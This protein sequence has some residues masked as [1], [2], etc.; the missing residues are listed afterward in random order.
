MLEHIHPDYPGIWLPTDE[1][2]H[3]YSH[4]RFTT[5]TDKDPVADCAAGV[6]IHNLRETMND[7]E[8]K[9]ERNFKLCILV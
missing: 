7:R 1:W 2:N 5:V 8:L 9:E 6:T 3:D 4:D